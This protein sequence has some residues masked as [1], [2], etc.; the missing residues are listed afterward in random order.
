MPAGNVDMLPVSLGEALTELAW[1]GVVR[2]TL[3]SQVHDRLLTASEQEWQTYKSQV[4]EWEFGRAFDA[5]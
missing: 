1:D 5:S 3:G 4:T 2:D